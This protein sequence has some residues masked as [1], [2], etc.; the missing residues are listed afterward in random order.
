MVLREYVVG[1]VDDYGR[2]SATASNKERKKESE[3]NGGREG[4]KEGGRDG[5]KEEWKRERGSEEERT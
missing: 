3:R 1:G 2:C 5:G 4:N